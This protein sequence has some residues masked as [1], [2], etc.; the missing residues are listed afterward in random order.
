MQLHT[1]AEDFGNVIFRY[2]ELTCQYHIDASIDIYHIWRT[3]D[4]K[5]VSQSGIV[6]VG[7]SF[8]RNLSSWI[9]FSHVIIPQISQRRRKTRRQ[10]SMYPTVTVVILFTR[11]LLRLY[12]VDRGVWRWEK[13][14]PGHMKYGCNKYINA[15]PQLCFKWF[16]VQCLVW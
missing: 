6:A 7:N 15:L 8:E 1:G 3:R 5:I 11:N 2:S 14:S 4:K 13:T 10:V 12:Q 16:S 9:V